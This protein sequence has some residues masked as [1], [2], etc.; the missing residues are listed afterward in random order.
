MSIT[1]TTPS[2]L[3]VLNQELDLNPDCFGELQS[4]I[5]IVNDAVALRTRMAEDGYLYLPG[6]LNREEVLDGRREV[7]DRIANSGAMH[8]DYLI[9]AAI[10]HPKNIMH[11]ESLNDVV[12][13]NNAVLKVLYD[14]AMMEFYERFLGGEVRHFDFT[15]FRIIPP[16][17]SSPPHMDSVYM[18]RGT[19]NL[20]TAWTPFGDVPLSMGGLMILEKSHLHERLNNNY[21]NKDVDTFCVNRSN[22]HTIGHGGS[23]SRNPVK[24]RQNLGG[25]WLST[26]FHAGDLLT[27]TIKTVHCGLDNR[28]AQY[29]LSSDTRYQLASEPADERWIGENPI[30]HGPNAKKGLIC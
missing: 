5:D 9:E 15:W 29:R 11:R 23:L 25:R 17:I 18:S 22:G 1:L 16:G 14:G 6:Y 7:L 21:G 3:S 13:G 2:T 28:S 27:F 4:S 30:A 12:Q 19:P 24:L 20:Y 8:P 10:P 26:N